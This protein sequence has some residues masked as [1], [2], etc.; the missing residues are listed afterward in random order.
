MEDGIMGKTYYISEVEYNEEIH[1]YCLIGEPMPTT[2]KTLRNAVLIVEAMGAKKEFSFN[3][4]GERKVILSHHYE[5][6]DG[7]TEDTTEMVYK[8]VY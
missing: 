5:F 7:T 6:S 3:D 4:N 1:D 8:L 2:C